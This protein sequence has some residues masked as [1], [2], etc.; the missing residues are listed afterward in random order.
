MFSALVPEPEAKI[1]IFFV[2]EGSEGFKKRQLEINNG[3]NKGFQ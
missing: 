2:D 3:K 1:T